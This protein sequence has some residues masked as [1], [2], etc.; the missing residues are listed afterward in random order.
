MSARAVRRTNVPVA[1][2]LRV[3]SLRSWVEAGVL[4]A[5]DVHFADWVARSSGISEPLVM[6]AGALASWAARRGHACVLLPQVRT[7]VEHDLALIDDRVD[8]GDALRSLDWPEPSAWRAALM[9][10][11]TAVRTVDDDLTPVLDGLPLVLRGNALYLQRHWVDECTVASQVRSRLGDTNTVL[12]ASAVKLLDR[13]LPIVDPSGAPNQQRKAAEL[14]VDRQLSLVVGGPGTGKTYSV[15]RILAVLIAE[16]LATGRMPR[17]ALTAP[18][19]KAKARLGETIRNAIEAKPGEPVLDREVAKVLEGIRPST[20]HGLLGA[21]GVD[22]QRF[23]RNAQNPLPHDVVVVD[24]TSMVSMPLLARLMEAVRPEA[25]LVLIGDPD[26][27]ESVELGSVL[28][29]L[30]S[31]AASADSSV[32]GHV[33][34]LTRV[35]RFEQDSPIALLADAVRDGDA[36]G[37]LG[38]LTAGEAIDLVGPGGE[39]RSSVRFVATPDPRHATAVDA[40]HQV[41]GPLLEGTRD[42]AVAGDAVAALERSIRARV[43]CA[44]REGPWGVAEWN[45]RAEEWMRASG[46]RWYPGRPVLVTR[47]D[48]RTSL[49]NGDTGVVILRNDRPAVVFADASHDAADPVRWFDPAQLDSVETAYAMTIHKSQGSEYGTVVLVL[50]PA[51]SPLVGRELVYTAVTRAKQHLVVVGS[52]AALRACVATPAR[53]MTGLAD[54]L[55]TA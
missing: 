42:A 49:S 25:R 11:D 41:L 39:V 31:A 46:G 47:N 23:P 24:E 51:T 43:L 32:H 9:S 19:G 28:R 20:I 8:A 38:R 45:R 18:T 52:E 4:D 10:A 33:V 54:S 30:V 34:R 1:V 50:P 29:D 15:A 26:Q 2:P 3:E 16:G 55:A 48:G 14:V 21:T 7:V 6:L 12:S 17:I 35:H 44:H 37:A 27:L 40:V 36:D 13:L 22:R 5:G 53:R